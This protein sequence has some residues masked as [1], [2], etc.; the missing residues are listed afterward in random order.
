MEPAIL[1][2]L[3]ENVDMFFGKWFDLFVALSGAMFVC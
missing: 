1:L 3:I 2:A